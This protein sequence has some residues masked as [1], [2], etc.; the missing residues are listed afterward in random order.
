MA[1]K[2]DADDV[3]ED[4]LDKLIQDISK[5]EAEDM[6]PVEESKPVLSMVSAP[7]PAPAAAPAQALTLELTGDINLKLCFSS[8]ERSI[9]VV[10]SED[11]LLCRMADGTEFKIP[12]GMHKKKAA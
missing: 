1:D 8:G 12:T 10:C 4:E 9:E 7:K 3:S 5:E 6:A 2:K 11:A